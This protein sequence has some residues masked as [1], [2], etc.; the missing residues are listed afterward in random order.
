MKKLVFLI[1]LVTFLLGFITYGFLTA[2]QKVD[3][4][5]LEMEGRDNRWES[6]I[7]KYIVDM[8]TPGETMDVE[9]LEYLKSF[10]RSLPWVNNAE[11]FIKSGTLIVKVKEEKIAF[12]LFYNGYTYLLSK[13]GFVLDEKKGPVSQEPIYYYKGKISP[14]IL[15]EGFL[16]LKNLVK[17]EISL[18]RNRLKDSEIFKLNPEITLTDVGIVLVFPK[19]KTIIYIDNTGSSWNNFLNF[20]KIAGGIVPGVYDFSFS[21]LLIRRRNQC[22]HKKS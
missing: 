6:K 16:R 7:S 13:E 8:T 19:T 1:G 17:M 21:N 5:K 9:E 20:V 3:S 4:L 15:E 12:S 18:L 2:P 11:I 14:F 10:I 22:S